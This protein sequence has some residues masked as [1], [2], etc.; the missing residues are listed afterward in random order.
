MASSALIVSVLRP[1]DFAVLN[2][3]PIAFSTAFADSTD[4]DVPADFVLFKVSVA[5]V[6]VSARAETP[7]LAPEPW[8]AEPF[9]NDAE[10]EPPKPAVELLVLPFKEDAVS[11]TCSPLASRALAAT[12]LLID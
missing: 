9:P 7:A 1:S 3:S 8:L 5:D 2:S 4:L 11:L 10:S 12:R 6:P